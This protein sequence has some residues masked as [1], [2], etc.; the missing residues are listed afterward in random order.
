[1]CFLLVLFEQGAQWVRADFH[2]HT[3]ADREFKYTG[4]DSYYYRLSIELIGDRVGNLFKVVISRAAVQ[5]WM[6]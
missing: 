6:K 5:R 3:R 2:M 4:D 1:M